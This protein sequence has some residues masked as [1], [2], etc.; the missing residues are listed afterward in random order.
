MTRQAFGQRSQAHGSRIVLGQTGPPPATTSSQL[1]LGPV[2]ARLLGE[3]HHLRSYSR[4]VEQPT[5]LQSIPESKNRRPISGSDRNRPARRTTYRS[6]LKKCR[7]ERRR[8]KSSKASRD[9]PRRKTHQPPAPP[10]SLMMNEEQ[11][12][13]LEK[14]IHAA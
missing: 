4:D 11:K 8:Q 3:D 2:P 6:R 14:Y 5:L 10:I 7:A 13:L 12:A 1:P 9:W